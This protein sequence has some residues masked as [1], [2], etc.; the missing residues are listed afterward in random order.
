[1]LATYPETFAGGAISGGLPYGMAVTVGEAFERMQGR[2]PPDIARLQSAL[3]GASHHRGPWPTVSIWHGTHDQTVRPRNAEQ[4]VRQ[5]S[6]VHALAE[7]G[8]TEIINGHAHTVWFDAKGRGL[9]E[10]Y[11]VKG[12][13]HGVPLATNGDAPIGR[14][15]PYM[16]E[17]GISSTV[18]I[19]HSWKL[20]DDADVKEA[21]ANS[22][23]FRQGRPDRAASVIE[24]ALRQA[25]PRANAAGAAQDGKIAKVIN[26][27]L[28][29]AGLMR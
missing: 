21:E 26:D 17:A 7:P 10:T 27:A 2:N 5:W 23:A 13:G 4:I 15:G 6:G 24:R 8:R 12:M 3:E 20:A 9:V 16:L 19:A 1:M 29:A 14:A 28:K 22:G 25:R 11:S 18:R